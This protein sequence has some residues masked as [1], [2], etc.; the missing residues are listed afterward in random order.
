MPSTTVALSSSAPAP[1]LSRGAGQG[2]G[3]EGQGNAGQDQTE[4]ARAR[5][6]SMLPNNARTRKRTT[7]PRQGRQTQI[8]VSAS[9]RRPRRAQEIAAAIGPQAGGGSRACRTRRAGGPAA[10]GHVRTRSAQVAP[11]RGDA[12]SARRRWRPAARR[13]TAARRAGD[14]IGRGGHE[15]QAAGHGREQGARPGPC[16]AHR[17]P[18]GQQ[19][20]GRPPSGAARARPAHAG[21]PPGKPSPVADRA[22]LSS[23][24]LPSS[25]MR[26]RPAPGCGRR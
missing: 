19:A 24:A 6:A 17:A 23:P 15:P 1:S 26:R 4:R 8:K 18:P 22:R 14:E 16:A 10:E 13:W 20:P 12:K 25:T 21:T 3:Q 7:G 9:R 2:A 11:R 5:R